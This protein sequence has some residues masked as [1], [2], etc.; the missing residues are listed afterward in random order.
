MNYLT[1][2]DL[3][4]SKYESVYISVYFAN[5]VLYLYEDK[6]LG[7][8]RPRK[9]IEAA[10]TWLKNPCKE[11]ASAAA[12]AASAASATYAASATS[13]SAANAASDSA[14][15]AAAAAY[16]AAYAAA[17]A[18]SAASA[19]SAASYASYA[20]YA[21]SAANVSK[22]INKKQFIHDHISTLLPWLLKNK[23]KEGSKLSSAVFDYL[24]DEDKEDAI[25]NL[26]LFA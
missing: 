10:E 6:H 14:A 3:N 8:Q 2:E 25:F 26:D 12:S 1:I 7:D 15:N 13:D 9:A 16:S 18:A 11:N 17:Y 19:T 21:T 20:A 23:I 5:K 24:S 4:L 22:Q